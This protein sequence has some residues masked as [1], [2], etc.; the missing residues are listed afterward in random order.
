[1]PDL[2]KPF[3]GLNEL[4]IRLES[5]AIRGSERKFYLGR[6]IICNSPRGRQNRKV[7]PIP[8]S[9]IPLATNHDGAGIRA[10][11]LASAMAATFNGMSR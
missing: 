4:P 9:L 1:L 6:V 3:R 11:L 8:G 10:I 2:R 7:L 5:N